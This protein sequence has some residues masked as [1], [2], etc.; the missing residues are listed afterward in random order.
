MFPACSAW[1][2]HVP[3]PSNVIV[4][5]LVPPAVHTAGVVVL[6]VTAN[7]ELAAAVADTGDCNVVWFAIALNVIDCVT[8][9]TVKL[10]STGGADA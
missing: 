4:A 1:T 5:P 9:D 7:P 2:V 8:C 3:A 10:R 6:N